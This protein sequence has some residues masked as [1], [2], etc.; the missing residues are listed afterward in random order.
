[1]RPVT[2]LEMFLEGKPEIE[3]RVRA[4]T[5]SQRDCL[6]ARIVLLRHQGVKQVEAA[7]RLGIRVASVNRWS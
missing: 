3:R 6:R 1:M 2:T 5:T 7:L 4:A